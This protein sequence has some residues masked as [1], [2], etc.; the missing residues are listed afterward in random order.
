[1]KPRT[2]AERPL[3]PPETGGLG[4]FGGLAASAAGSPSPRDRGMSGVWGCIASSAFAL[5]PVPLSWR[6]GVLYC[7]GCAS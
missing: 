7:E 4:W 6:A 1:M 3:S 2:G 5:S